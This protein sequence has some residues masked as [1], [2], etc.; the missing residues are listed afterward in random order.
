MRLL[1]LKEKWLSCSSCNF[2]LDIT[3]VQTYCCCRLVQGLIDLDT[4]LGTEH[5]RFG[6]SVFQDNLHDKQTIVQNLLFDISLGNSCSVCPFTDA[7]CYTTAYLLLWDVVFQM[8]G[9]ASSELRSQYATYIR[10]FSHCITA[11]SCT[12]TKLVDILRKKMN[13]MYHKTCVCKLVLNF[14]C[15]TAYFLF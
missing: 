2:F 13:M 8:C 10:Y 15:F 11:F 9:L 6:L 3:V 12:C 4:R 14:V 5:E 7:Y 1:P